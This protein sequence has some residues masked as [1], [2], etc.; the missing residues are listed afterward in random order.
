M[1]AISGV[2]DL[3]LQCLPMPHKKDAMFIWVNVFSNLH[4]GMNV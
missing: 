1:Q 4:M 3:G 2:P